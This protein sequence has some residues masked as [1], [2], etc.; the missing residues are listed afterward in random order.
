MADQVAILDGQ[1]PA[2]GSNRHA[3]ER[4]LDA[5]DRRRRPLTGCVSFINGTGS[6]DT[7]RRPQEI[8]LHEPITG[9]CRVVVRPEQ[10]TIQAAAGNTTVLGR[11]FEGAGYELELKTPAGILIAHVP[12]QHAPAVNETVSIAIHG[13]CAAVS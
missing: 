3:R 1:S 5:C 13:P 12:A 10:I 6:G 9:A 2:F 4:L 8:V 11:R 7:A